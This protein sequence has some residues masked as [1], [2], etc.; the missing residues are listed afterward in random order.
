M[1]ITRREA[2]SWTTAVGAIGLLCQQLS[3]VIKDQAEV[4]GNVGWAAE[5]I[6]TLKDRIEVLEAK[7][8]LAIDVIAKGR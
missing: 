6:T 1:P 3:G 4:W 5:E 2:V 8:D 7:L